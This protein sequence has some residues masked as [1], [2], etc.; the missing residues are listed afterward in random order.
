MLRRNTI[1]LLLI[2]PNEC[3]VVLNFFKK[4]SAH[5]YFG[6]RI[7]SKFFGGKI[8]ANQEGNVDE[9]TLGGK[10]YRHCS[11]PEWNT[12]F[13]RRSVQ[14]SERFPAKRLSFFF[15]EKLSSY[16]VTYLRKIKRISRQQ[17]YSKPTQ[18][19]FG[20]DENAYVE[21]I[22]LPYNKPAACRKRTDRI[23]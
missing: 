16:L 8:T 1:K 20:N 18:W 11:E 15:C 22:S 12:L 4:N 6:H 23:E 7:F 9:K 21:K 3:V 19:L 10:S 5:A 13:M 14:K 2:L 17:A